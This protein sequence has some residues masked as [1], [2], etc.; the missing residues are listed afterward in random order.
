MKTKLLFSRWGVIKDPI[1]K[2]S[3]THH[4]QRQAQERRTFFFFLE[5]VEKRTS[6]ALEL[7]DKHSTDHSL[8]SDGETEGK[9]QPTGFLW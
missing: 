5:L 4:G 8:I 9:T 2:R 7:T 3:M 6:L 1:V